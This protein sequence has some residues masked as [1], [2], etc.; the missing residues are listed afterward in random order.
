MIAIPLCRRRQYGQD[1]FAAA[2]KLM[3]RTARKIRTR[4]RHH[5]RD[6]ARR[7]RQ[8]L[9]QVVCF[10]CFTWHENLLK[11]DLTFTG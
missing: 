7:V 10:Q 5:A 11:K 8:Y 2:G 1:R 3:R 9:P 4:A 6:F